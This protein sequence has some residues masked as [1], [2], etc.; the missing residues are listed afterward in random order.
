MKQELKNSNDFLI[1]SQH[2]KV[3]FNEISKN[4][5]NKLFASAILQIGIEKPV[6]ESF[7]YIVPD[8]GYFGK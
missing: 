3:E 7:C 8:F 4:S 6:R 5:D 1:N 2:I